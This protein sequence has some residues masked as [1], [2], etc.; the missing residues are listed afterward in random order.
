[1]TA[2]GGSAKTTFYDLMSGEPANRVVKRTSGGL[3]WA[4]AQGPGGCA[5]T[6]LLRW[7]SVATRGKQQFARAGLRRGPDRECRE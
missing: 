7:R 4:S 1:M 6:E 2:Q 3:V 5:R